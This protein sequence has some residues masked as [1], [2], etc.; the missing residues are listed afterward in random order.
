MDIKSVR[1][2]RRA[3]VVEYENEGETHSVTSRDNPLPSFIKAV[4][5]LA[6]LVLDICHLPSDYIHG[7]KPSGITLVTKQETQMVVVTAQKEL[8]DANSPFNI[9]TPLRF[10]SVPKE[11][12]SYSPPLKEAQVEL[13]DEVISQA[14][15]YVKGDR[16]QGQLPLEVEKNAGADDET[17]PDKLLPFGG[18]GG[19][20]EDADSPAP[21][22]KPT[23]GKKK[24]G[25]IRPRKAGK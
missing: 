11:E 4:E 14:K 20:G 3:V 10:L 19:Q 8:T 21:A 17:D 25:A 13:V 23:K 2:K 5:A 12:G 22:E 24:P 18:E 1:I 15:K 6:P 16:A 7:L 9:A